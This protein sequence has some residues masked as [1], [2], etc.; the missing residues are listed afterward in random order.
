M[1]IT[2]SEQRR[3]SILEAIVEAY[4]ET[5]SPVG[6]ELIS[7]TLRPSLS[8]ATIRNVM[9]DL[10]REGLV[11]QPH[12]SAGRVPTDRG[13]RRYVDAVMEKTSFSPDR[14]R[15]IAE[16]IEPEELDVTQLFQRAGE[17]LSDLAH[18]AVY[19]VAPT[20]RRSRVKQ[21]EFVPLSVRKV[22]CVLVAN[23]EM[24]ASHVVEVTEP[25][26]R[27]DAT[28]LAR[29]LNTELVGLP[30]DELLSSLQRRLLAQ[31]DA[32]YY[33]AK[34]SLDILHHA[35]STEP[36][37]RLWLEG[38]SY[39]VSQ[40]EFSRY[41]RKTH[42][43]LKHVE[44][45]E[46]L[47]ECLRPDIKSDGVCVRIGREVRMPGLDECSFVTAPFSVGQDVVGGIGV[48]GPTRMDYRTMHAM[49]EGMARALTELLTRWGAA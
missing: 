46:D 28:A 5:A 9:A 39:L 14:V 11:E 15:Q 44:S 41:P 1:N 21:I 16:A 45:Q 7:R 8:S 25:I 27:D 33:L 4:V 6:S 43:V 20:V 24:I 31:Q 32:L 2:D 10:E 36:E 18:Q 17:V 12:T 40:P 3:N 30:F 23:E 38:T 26:S 22:L 42:D 19:V 47:L 48:M 35:L 29:F 37:E 13:Y 49:V 34:R